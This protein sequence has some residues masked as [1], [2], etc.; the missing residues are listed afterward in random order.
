[1][2]R[3][4]VSCPGRINPGETVPGTHFI[5]DEWV[6]EPVAGYSLPNILQT[7]SGTHFI[8]DEWVQSRSAGYSEGKI[9][10]S[11]CDSSVA[12]PAASPHADRAIS[13]LSHCK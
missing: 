6:P 4:T 1:M 7:G 2:Q 10:D 12:Q 11:N 3:P 13:G 8:G 9:V 5:G